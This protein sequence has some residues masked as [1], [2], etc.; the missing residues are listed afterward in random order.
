MMRKLIYAVG[1]ISFLLTLNC[2]TGNKSSETLTINISKTRE[3]VSPYIYGQFIEHL[4]RCIYGGIWAEMLEDRKFFYPVTDKYSPWGTQKDDNWDAG[5]FEILTASPW[6]RI[7]PEGKIHMTKINPF[8]GQHTPEIVL[9]PSVPTGI[10]QEGLYLKKDM[11][12]KGHVVL[13]AAGSGVKIR[14]AVQSAEDKEI[15]IIDIDD[16]SDVYKSYEFSFTAP[17]ESDEATI[18]ITATGTGTLRIGTIS[19]MPGDN[20]NGFNREVL[21]YLKELNSPVYR[22]PGGNFVSG[23]NWRDGIGDRDKRPP[24]KNPAWTGVEHNDVGIHEFMDL[25]NLLNTEPYI[26][27]NTGL[28]TVEEVAQQVEYINGANSTSLGKLRSENGHSEPYN[29]KFWAVGNEMYGEWQLGYMP[30]TDYVKKHIAVAEAMRN[31]DPSIK[32]VG[33]GSVGKWSQTM[34]TEGGDHM[35]LVSEHIY[36][37]ELADVKAH[38]AQI[39]DNI[40]RVADE[41]RKYRAEIPGLAEKDIRI[42][43]DEWNYWHGD[44]IYGELGCRYY[45]KDGMGIAAGFHEYFR[46]SDLFYMANYAQTVNVIGAIKTTK[47]DVQFETTGIIQKLYRQHFGNIPLETEGYQGPLDISVATD[48]LKTLLTI[49][50][51]NTDSISHDLNLKMIDGKIKGVDSCF[52]VSNPDPLSY[53]EPGK[54]RAVDISMVEWKSTDYIVVNPMSVIIYKFKLSQVRHP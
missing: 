18:I 29:V 2:C 19:L 15:D 13:S 17:E 27:V 16:V 25:C 45:W 40:R 7:G 3:P 53:N 11:S 6:K 49:A 54:D 41:H 14:L 1:I 24:R 43:M 23:Y 37:K 39:P 4:G 47:K 22:W 12:Y 30:L 9:S 46:N 42:T 44:Y 48:S 26:A 10:S 52:E 51:I 28:G 38:V 33:V 50:I 31:V 20:I 35:D 8:T 5:E 32:L 34:L 21:S 36:C